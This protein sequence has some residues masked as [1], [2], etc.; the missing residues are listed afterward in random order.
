MEKKNSTRRK[1]KFPRA[2]A[3]TRAR[4]R[5]RARASRVLPVAI[6]AALPVARVVALPVAGVAALP[7]AGV[8][9]LPVAEVAVVAIATATTCAV[10]ASAIVEIGVP[11]IASKTFIVRA[12]VPADAI[13]VYAAEWAFPLLPKVSRKMRLR[14][15]RTTLRF[16]LKIPCMTLI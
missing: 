2:R 14:L 4:T 13:V 5:A 10:D 15:M 7:V 12:V 3:R 6:T 11:V 9:A 1:N 8:A 16:S